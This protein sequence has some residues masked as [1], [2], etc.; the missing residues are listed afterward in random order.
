LLGAV[1]GA[2]QSTSLDATPIH[3]LQHDL[4]PWGLSG[5]ALDEITI[6]VRRVSPDE[7]VRFIEGKDTHPNWSGA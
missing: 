7:P 3:E 4:E 1:R 2:L 5:L 6:S